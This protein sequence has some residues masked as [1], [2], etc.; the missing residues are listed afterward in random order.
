MS[1][2]TVSIFS[3]PIVLGLAS[4][5]PLVDGN[6]VGGG[7]PL[8]ALDIVYSIPEIAEALGQV[9]LQ[10]IS[11]Q[12]FQVWAEVGWKANLQTEESVWYQTEALGG[13]IV[14]FLTIF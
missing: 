9:H 14:I 3:I 1:P 11:Q 8:V 4:Y 10:Q 12:I 5:L 6:P 13:L 7:K 2:Q